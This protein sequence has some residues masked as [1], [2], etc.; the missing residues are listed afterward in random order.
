[1]HADVYSTFYKF[2][3]FLLQ[4]TAQKSTLINELDRCLPQVYSF[5][6]MC[7]FWTCLFLNIVQ[8]VFEQEQNSGV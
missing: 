1:M 3:Q 2:L 4:I 6:H 7:F 8:T 5:K